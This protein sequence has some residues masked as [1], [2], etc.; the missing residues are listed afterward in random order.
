MSFIQRMP[1]KQSLVHRWEISSGNITTIA[2]TLPE[3]DHITWL[4]D[5]I[6]L[7]GKDDKLFSFKTGTD[8]DWKE[9]RI[10]DNNILLKGI[11]RLAANTDNTKLAVVISE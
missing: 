8:K 3:Q 1:D 10:F 11:T 6:I 5:N 4:Q 2:R 9:I 7:S